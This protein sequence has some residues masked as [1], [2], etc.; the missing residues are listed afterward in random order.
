MYFFI[1]NPKSRSGR[2]KRIWN[3]IEPLLLQKSIE[4]QV[5]FTEYSHHAIE[6]ARKLT[7]DDQYHTII[8]LGGDGTIN[9]FL[10]GT[11][12]LSKITL[13]YIP[14]G[15][16]NDFARDL[17]LNADPAK[18]LETILQPK[19][20]VY[21]DVGVITYKDGSRQFSVS[22]GIGFD[23]AVCFEALESKIKDFLNKI[24]LGKLTYTGIALR[25]LKIHKPF[26]CTLLLDGYKK[27]E[28]KKCYF[29]AFMI[30]KYEGGGFKFCP[31]A[32]YNDSFLDICLVDSLTKLQ[33]LF[34]LPTAFWGYHTK[35]KG[36]H[37][38]RCKTA[39]LTASTPLPVHT[40]GESCGFQNEIS[41]TCTNSKL[42]VII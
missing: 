11:S 20:Y 25:Q 42:R 36:I 30:H 17:Q 35:I 2:G 34:M 13:G 7:S 33:V 23:A 41:V 19:K 5:Y 26:A 37:I 31:E 38:F 24:N 10:C 32:D 15:S 29:A 22:T 12:N 4:F 9:E 21:K 6:I 14:T 8:I 40:D 18:A 16:S 28:F 1:V 27:M 3:L 39:S